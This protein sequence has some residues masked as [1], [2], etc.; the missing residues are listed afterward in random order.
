MSMPRNWLPEIMYEED[1]PGQAATLPFILVPLE[2][3]MPMFLMLWEHKDTGECEPGP[4]GEDLP[5]VQPE[6][7]QYARMDVL[8]DELSADAYDDVRVALGLAPLQA[9]TKMGQRI[10]SRASTAAALAS[11]TDSE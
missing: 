5:I 10:T 4:D 6:L 3:E 9:A 2:E 7:R 8:K 11:Q 1:L